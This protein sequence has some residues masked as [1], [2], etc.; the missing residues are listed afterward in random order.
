M[1]SLQQWLS[2]L[3]WTRL[4]RSSSSSLC[5]GEHQ[6]VQSERSTNNSATYQGSLAAG[7]TLRPILLESPS[8]WRGSGL[9]KNQTSNSFSAPSKNPTSSTDRHR[10]LLDAILTSSQF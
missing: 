8:D 1:D 2:I 7:I 9:S 4:S 10:V 6:Q 5:T 3:Q